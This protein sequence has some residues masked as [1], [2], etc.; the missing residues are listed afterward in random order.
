MPKKRTQP[1]VTLADLMRPSVTVK[2]SHDHFEHRGTSEPAFETGRLS[3]FHFRVGIPNSLPRHL[4]IA[5]KKKPG[6]GVVVAATMA[7]WLAPLG[8]DGL[9]PA[10]DWIEVSTE[11]RREGLGTELYDGVEQYTGW[12]INPMGTFQAFERAIE[13]ARRQRI[14]L[15]SEQ[16]RAN[17]DQDRV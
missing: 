12:T 10:C 9:T 5:F 2:V 4:F 6:R 8:K 17:V 13:R 3:V 7:V 15:T 14:P 1:P 11:F 16:R